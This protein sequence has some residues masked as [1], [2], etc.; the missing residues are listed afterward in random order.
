MDV[1]VC[2][3]LFEQNTWNETIWTEQ[4]FICPRNSETG[5]EAYEHGAAKCLVPWKSFLL[6][7]NLV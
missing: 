5:K 4:R 1:I 2:F 6:P 7:H 3:L